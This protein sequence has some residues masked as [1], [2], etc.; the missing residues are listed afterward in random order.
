MSLGTSLAGAKHADVLINLCKQASQAADQFARIN[1]VI[2]VDSKS[3]EQ[4]Q[5]KYRDYKGNGYKI[6]TFKL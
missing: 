5:N 3:L 2:S 6:E 4:G 1:E